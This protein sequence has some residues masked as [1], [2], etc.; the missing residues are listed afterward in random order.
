[1]AK[2]TVQKSAGRLVMK[3]FHE[4]K[5]YDEN[6]A[7]GI[8]QF[9][10]VPLSSDMIGYT[11][12]NLIQEGVVVATENESYYFSES[13]WKKVERKVNLV[14]WIMILVPFLILLGIVIYQNIDVIRGWF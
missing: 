14:Y 1:M 8:E 6:S 12:G 13:A 9:K 2:E 4:H 3:V 11:F 10:N 5:A 7:L